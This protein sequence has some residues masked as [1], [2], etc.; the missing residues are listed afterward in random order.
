MNAQIHMWIGISVLVVNLVVGLWALLAAR[1]GLF[2]GRLLI[3]GF[4]VGSALLLVQVLLG[5]DLWFRMGLRPAPG[6]LGIVHVAGPLL[7]LVAA[8]IVE[9]MPAP[10]LAGRYAFSS[11]LTFAVALLSYGIGEMGRR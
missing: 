11:L 9:W 10:K 2:A 5:L 6:A 4:S 8:I 3:V 7:A 1:K